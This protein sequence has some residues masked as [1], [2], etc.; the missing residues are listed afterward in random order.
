MGVT[1]LLVRSLEIGIQTKPQKVLNGIFKE[2][3]I[4]AN[5]HSGEKL[6]ME[7]TL[8]DIKKIFTE[9]KPKQGGK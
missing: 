7:F 3:F 2:H 4:F 9:E 6:V 1:K 5:N 8:P